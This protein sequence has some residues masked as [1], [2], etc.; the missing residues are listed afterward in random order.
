MNI[1]SKDIVLEIGSGHNPDP[2]SDILCDKYLE[3]NTQRRGGI[4]KG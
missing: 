1:G 4:K 2:R 3:D